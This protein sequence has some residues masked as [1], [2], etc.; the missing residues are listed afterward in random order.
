M[1]LS[2]HLIHCM[3]NW[4]TPFFNATLLLSPFVGFFAYF[5]SSSFVQRFNSY[6]LLGGQAPCGTEKIFFSHFQT[7]V[8]RQQFTLRDMVGQ[9]AKKIEET[10]LKAKFITLVEDFSDSSGQCL[11]VS[12]I[13]KMTCPYLLSLIVMIIL[14][15]CIS[16][17]K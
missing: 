11:T 6:L 12:L 9:K 7:L 1:S 17:V 14:A 4:M 13:K 15:T 2:F 10:Y 3:E 5:Y 8:K 16:L